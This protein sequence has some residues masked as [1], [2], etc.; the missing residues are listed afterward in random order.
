[1]TSTEPIMRLRY[2]ENLVTPLRRILA[3]RLGLSSR[4][5][6]LSVARYMSSVSCFLKMRRI[7]CSISLSG[8]LLRDTQ[9]ALSRFSTFRDGKS[10]RYSESLL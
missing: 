9:T 6:F 7:C 1:M 8:E 10:L 2:T 5:S 3:S 4:S